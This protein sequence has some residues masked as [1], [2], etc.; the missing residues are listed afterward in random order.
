MKIS[1]NNLSIIVINYNGASSLQECIQSIAGQL[2]NEDELILI[3]N[4]SDDNSKI[5]MMQEFKNNDC[6][7]RF[8]LDENLGISRGRN[9]GAKKA[10]HD[11]LMFIDSDLVL[12]PYSVKNARETM[13]KKTDAITGEYFDIGE[14]YAWFNELKRNA[15]SRK[16]KNTKNIQISNSNYFTFS[17]GLCVIRKE[18]YCFFNGFNCAFDKGSAE[19]IDF[20][21]KLLNSNKVILLEKDFR[22]IHKKGHVSIES[23]IKSAKNNGIGVA[24]LLKS[25]KKNKYIVSFNRYYPKIPLIHILL[26]L[27]IIF[28]FIHIAIFYLVF[29][30]IIFS[31]YSPIFIAKGKL[32]H[33]FMALY[34]LPFT[35]TIWLYFILKQL[36]AVNKT[37]RFS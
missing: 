10:R 16:R 25:A 8:F 30:I 37:G 20:E 4:N 32:K 35:D 24:N 23:V 12:N 26:L 3:D 9:L 7:Q 13:S 31:Y 15:F 28:L 5:I 27:S 11:L 6:I 22:G 36:S 29:A 33:K 19:D 17:G 2:E 21:F 1:E 34:I 14:G 18:I